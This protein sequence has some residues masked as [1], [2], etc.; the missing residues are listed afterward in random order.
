MLVKRGATSDKKDSKYDDKRRKIG[1]QNFPQK[2]Q[3]KAGQKKER[4]WKQVLLY[5][6]TPFLFSFLSKHF[7]EYGMLN[8]FYLPVFP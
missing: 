1:Q 2:K 6:P 8:N 5:F 7:C 4:N 3:S